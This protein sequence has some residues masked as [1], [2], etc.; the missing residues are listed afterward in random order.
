[1]QILAV[2]GSPHRNG[3]TAQLINEASQGAREMSAD[4]EVAMLA[5]K[6]V[7]P[8]LACS[9]PPCWGKMDCT[10]LDDDG[11]E[12][13]RM[14]NESDALIIGAPVYFL[15]ANGLTKDFIDRMR[16]Y[17]ESGKPA[18][19]ISIAGG[20]GKGCIT[21]LR[22]MCRW[23]VILGFRP[24]MPLPVTRY[25]WDIAQIESRERGKRLVNEY[26]QLRPFAGLAEQIAWHESL[27]FMR[28]GMT[29]EIA[30]LARIAIEGIARRG[31]ADLTSKQR[32]R[33]QKA[34]TMIS[35]GK[36]EEGLKEAVAVQEESM[37]IFNRNLT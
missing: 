21:A 23:L 28:W 11:L 18:F 20:T 25:D 6:N 14:M 37:A 16:Y 30:Y 22:E 10:I 15:S 8:C 34:E 36:I 4:V 27:P 26:G 35:R 29:E 7:K 32:D 13:R 19:P 12:L 24:F 1:M 5:E 9:N 31:R 33:L 2:S 17:G 3:L